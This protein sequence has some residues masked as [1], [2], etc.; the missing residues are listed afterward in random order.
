[1]SGASVNCF[2][3]FWVSGAI[4]IYLL[5]FINEYGDLE[6]VNPKDWGENRWD[7]RVNRQ[8]KGDSGK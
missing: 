3:F 7:L 8:G 6:T 2:L 5:Q 4:L 1:M